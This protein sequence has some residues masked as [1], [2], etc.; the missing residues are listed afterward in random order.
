[1]IEEFDATFSFGECS[2]AALLYRYN[3]FSH[4]QFAMEHNGP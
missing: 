1:M 3:F 4:R 2:L